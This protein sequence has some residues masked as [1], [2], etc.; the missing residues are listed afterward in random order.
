[1]VRVYCLFGGLVFFSARWVATNGGSACSGPPRS[2]EELL[3]LFLRLRFC[4]R[5]CR[6]R[7]DFFFGRRKQVLPGCPRSLWFSRRFARLSRP[8]DAR[9]FG[10]SVSAGQT[11]G[12]YF[13]RF[14]ITL[15]TPH[16]P[17]RVSPPVPNRTF[18]VFFD[19]QPPFC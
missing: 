17:G 16:E 7:F 1:M 15:L 10:D 4:I 5:A 6:G 14:D 8:C 9:P 18:Q 13:F 19:P 11:A 12:T 3:L 2:W